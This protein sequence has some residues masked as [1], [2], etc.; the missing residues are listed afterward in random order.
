MIPTKS[1]APESVVWDIKRE[2]RRH[3]N[4]KEKIRSILEGWKGE[5]SIADICRKESL[6][7]TKY[8]KWSKE[9]LKA[10]NTVFP[11]TK[12]QLFIVNIIWN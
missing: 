11:K 1:F 12:V 8:Y 9:I 4:A 2:T 10:M 7:P 6:H 3:F 5:D